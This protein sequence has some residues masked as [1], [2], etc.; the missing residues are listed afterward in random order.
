MRLSLDADRVGPI[1]SIDG[2]HLFL[3]ISVCAI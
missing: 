1:M 2:A 3:F